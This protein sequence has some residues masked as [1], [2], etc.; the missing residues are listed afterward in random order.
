MGQFANLEADLPWCECTSPQRASLEESM[1]K[2]YC[3]KN[4]SKHFVYCNLMQ[5]TLT[6]GNLYVVSS[7]KRISLTVQTMTAE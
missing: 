3:F 2:G 5:L 1:L 4:F 7:M 6:T